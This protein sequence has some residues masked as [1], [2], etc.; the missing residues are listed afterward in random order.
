MV[1]WGSDDD[2]EMLGAKTRQMG[3]TTIIFDD[4]PNNLS[5]FFGWKDDALI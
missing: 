1:S 2:G 5:C 3:A 4:K